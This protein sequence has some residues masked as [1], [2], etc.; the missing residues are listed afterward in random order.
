MH[1]ED[2]Y[3][4]LVPMDPILCKVSPYLRHITQSIVIMKGK[5]NQIV[6]DGSTILKPIDIVMN[7][8]TPN[9]FWSRQDASLH[10]H[11]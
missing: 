6:W 3:S 4:H 2:Y 5:N 9:H 1:K 10:W 11:L 8:I 7:N